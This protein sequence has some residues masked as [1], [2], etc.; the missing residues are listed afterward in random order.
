MARH[1]SSKNIKRDR[2]ST[3]P[4]AVKQGQTNRKQATFVNN[5]MVDMWRKIKD[6]CFFL[7][8]GPTF[9]DQKPLNG[10]V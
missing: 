4:L 8:N 9:G 7:L 6:L 3:N 5:G 2:E 1:T 10:E